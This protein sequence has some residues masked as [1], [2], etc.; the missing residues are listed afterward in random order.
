MN[1]ANKNVFFAM[2]S[3]R[4]GCRQQEPLAQHVAVAA[5]EMLTIFDTIIIARPTPPKVDET[6]HQLAQ[7]VGA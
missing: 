2:A 7:G 3:C 4:C 6:E 5:D 1:E